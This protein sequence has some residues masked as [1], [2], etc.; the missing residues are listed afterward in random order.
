[1]LAFGFA[2]LIRGPSG[3]FRLQRAVAVD[4]IVALKYE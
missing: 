4:R 1:V 3:L 2:A